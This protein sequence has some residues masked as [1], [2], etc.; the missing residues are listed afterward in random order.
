MEE[1]DINEDCD[2]D[3]NGDKWI[4]EACPLHERTRDMVDRCEYCDEHGFV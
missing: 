3:E 1:K 4:W 2:V